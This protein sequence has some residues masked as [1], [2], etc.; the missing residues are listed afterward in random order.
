M[1]SGRAPPPVPDSSSLLKNGCGRRVRHFAS[2]AP[3]PRS[4]DPSSPTKGCRQ[5]A[6]HPSG[7][8]GAGPSAASSLLDDAKASPSSRFL[9]SDPA[10]LVT[11]SHTLFQQPAGVSS[12]RSTVRGGRHDRPREEQSVEFTSRGPI[13][14]P[15]SRGEDCAFPSKISSSESRPVDR[16]R[17]LRRRAV[18]DSAGGLPGDRRLLRSLEA[19]RDPVRLRRAGLR[20][21]EERSHQSVRE[22]EP[23]RPPRFSPTSARRF[24]T[25]GTAD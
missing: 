3:L 25:T 1:I 11:P 6:V 12:V 19:D 4:I 24:T 10:A 21:G 22:P 16:P 9:A 15:G 17:P 18:G 13:R 23:R 20:R 5:S 2:G 7:Y 14:P 8:G